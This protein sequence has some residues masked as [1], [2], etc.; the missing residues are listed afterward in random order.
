[1]EITAN[2]GVANLQDIHELTN[3][4][5]RAINVIRFRGKTRTIRDTAPADNN[6]VWDE[7]WI[8]SGGQ[9]TDLAPNA[10]NAGNNGN[11]VAQSIIIHI[12]FIIP[13]IA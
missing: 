12:N 1:M 7:Y 13:N 10:P 11:V 2:I 4:Q 9:P 3:N 8:T 5:I 6:S